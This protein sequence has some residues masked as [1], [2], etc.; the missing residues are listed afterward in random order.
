MSSPSNR[1]NART[2]QAGKQRTDWQACTAVKCKHAIQPFL[3]TV[4]QEPNLTCPPS[5]IIASLSGVA[6]FSTTDHGR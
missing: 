6:L 1:Y 3:R 5:A 2:R 4:C